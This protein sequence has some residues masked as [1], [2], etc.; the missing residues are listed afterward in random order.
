MNTVVTSR[1]AILQTCRE[2]VS[3]NGLSALTMRAVA[4]RCH[5]A[6]GSL[7]NYFP[8]K[9]ELT[10][11]AIESVWQDIFRMDRGCCQSVSFPDYVQWIFSRVQ[12][13]MVE[14]PNFF[15]AHS[16]SFASPEKGEAK[17]TMEHYFEHMKAGLNQALRQDKRVRRDAFEAF[18]PEQLSDF[19]LSALLALLV[20]RTPDCTVLLQ[21]LRRTLY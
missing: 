3:E 12:A 16:L 7:Y 17:R 18:S 20:Q 13:G 2:L 15:T 19:V 5:V 21:M 1:E 4:D 10:I 9:S 8:S 11:A 14:Y 6:L